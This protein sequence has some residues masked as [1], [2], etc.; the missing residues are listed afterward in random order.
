MKTLVIYAHPSH[1]GHHGYF[2]ALCEQYFKENN[3]DFETLDLY[4]DSYDPRLRAEELNAKDRQSQGEVKMYQEKIIAADKLVFIY[5]TWWQGTPAILKGFFDR[6]LSSQFGFRYRRGI[7]TGLLKGKQAAVFSASGAPRWYNFLIL[8]DRALRTVT[9]DTLRFC[10]IKCKG[11][12][13]GSARK[14]S[15][16]AKTRIA[17]RQRQ[18][19]RYLYR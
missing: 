10:G 8:R 18:A 1:A 4:Q 13:I 14:L 16:R 2:L 7:P 11:F 3:L 9:H 6:V 17:S 5:P 12:S 15:N 19:M